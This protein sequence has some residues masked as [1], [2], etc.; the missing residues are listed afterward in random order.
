MS[1]YIPQII[2]IVVCLLLAAFFSM[3]E[4][5]LTML[6][7]IRLRNML[8]EGE[9]GAVIIEKVTRDFK[10]L[11]STV[12]LGVNFSNIALSAVATAV[13]ISVWGENNL[14]VFVTTIIVTMVILV[15]CDIFPKT[16]AST[17]PKRYAKITAPLIYP[18]III[19]SPLVNV[20][21][22]CV[23][24]PI[25]L[26]TGKSSKKDVSLTESEIET[27][28]DIGLEEGVLEEEEHKLIS[29]VFEFNNL[30]AKDVMIPRTDIISAP[31]G[32][33][34]DELVAAFRHGRFSMLPIYDEDID[35]IIGI[36]H[37]KDLFFLDENCRNAE[38]LQAHMRTPVFSYENKPLNELFREMHLGDVQMVVIVDEYGGTSGLLTIDDLINEITGETPRGEPAEV[39]QTGEYEYTAAGDARLDEVNEALELDLVSEDAETIGG[40]I[41]G[42]LDDMPEEGSPKKPEITE[43]GICY[44]VEE[45][46]KNRITKVR[47]VIDTVSHPK[48]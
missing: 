2:I 33:S 19:F 37:L 26:L 4:T 29:S 14:A 21:N 6:N 5:A 30:R 23:S 44:I 40:Y 8:D 10:G 15:F 43:N 13:V 39:I 17:N 41:L 48:G 22:L 36:L 20:L 35:H 46:E 45:M 34:Y 18:F 32:A 12:L 3:S 28:V 47:I 31:L 16:L 1:E 42:L 27:I 7:K 24:G 38:S 9:K 11:L 25:R